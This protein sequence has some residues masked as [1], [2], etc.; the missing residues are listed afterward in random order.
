MSIRIY[1]TEPHA[2]FDGV[3][4]QALGIISVDEN[5][6]EV[7]QPNDLAFLITE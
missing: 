4:L 2:L 6:L 5:Q 7:E 3:D 1:F